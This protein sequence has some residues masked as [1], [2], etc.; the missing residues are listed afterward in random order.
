MREPH[1]SETAG[2]AGRR[3]KASLVVWML[4]CH[5]LSNQIAK[6]PEEAG[7]DDPEIEQSRHRIARSHRVPHSAER[8]AK[9]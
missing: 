9:R 8:R 6:D 1:V 7:R 5:L 4:I 2:L 3:T